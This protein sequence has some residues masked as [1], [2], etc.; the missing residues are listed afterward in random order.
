MPQDGRPLQV[1]GDC[2]LGN[3]SGK[4]WEQAIL[5]NLEIPGLD[6]DLEIPGLD[7]PRMDDLFPK[8]E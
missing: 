1:Q 4:A 3:E 2:V 8:I 5:E 7:L 6:I